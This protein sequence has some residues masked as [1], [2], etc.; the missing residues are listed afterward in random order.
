MP[1]PSREK[2]PQNL[3]EWWVGIGWVVDGW[4]WKLQSSGEVVPL[5]EPTQFNPKEG[6]LVPSIEHLEGVN[7]DPL[8][9]GIT[10][11]RSRRP[12]VERTR[13]D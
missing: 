3:V 2:V 11:C 8:P 6:P 5:P 12:V 10:N 1:N 13:M 7:G 9:T 4:T